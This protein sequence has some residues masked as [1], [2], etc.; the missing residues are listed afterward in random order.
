[1]RTLRKFELIEAN[2]F[3]ILIGTDKLTKIAHVIQ[4]NRLPDT[5]KHVTL[6][7]VI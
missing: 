1:M 7:D 2:D 3:F 6:R 4:L 5:D